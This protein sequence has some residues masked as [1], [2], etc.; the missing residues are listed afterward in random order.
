[1][2]LLKGLKNAII[3][4]K[5]CFHSCRDINHRRDPADSKKSGCFKT[6]DERSRSYHDTFQKFM[7]IEAST[8]DMQISSEIYSQTHLPAEQ[9]YREIGGKSILIK[10]WER[11]AR[12][13]ASSINRWMVNL[14]VASIQL[15]GMFRSPLKSLWIYIF[16]RCH[17][18]EVSEHF[19]WALRQVINNILRDRLNGFSSGLKSNIAVLYPTF[20]RHFQLNVMQFQHVTSPPNR[21]TNKNFHIDR[22]T[23]KKVFSYWFYVSSRSRSKDP[24]PCSF[25]RSVHRNPGTRRLHKSKSLY[26]W[27]YV[28]MKIKRA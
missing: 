17:K 19:L 24:F 16:S 26:L 12:I 5:I 9:L 2:S 23:S 28:S 1:M 10:T 7:Q 22:W 13:S 3:I 20:R 11:I 27:I 25:Q 18:G 15:F 8:W 6:Q 21:S 14:H 4:N